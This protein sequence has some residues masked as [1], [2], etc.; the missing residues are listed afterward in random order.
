MLICHFSLT[1]NSKSCGNSTV[2][3]TL[4]LLVLPQLLVMSYKRVSSC[5]FFPDSPSTVAAT[6]QRCHR[7]LPCLFLL[8][9]MPHKGVSICHFSAAASGSRLLTSKLGQ[10]DQRHRHK[11]VTERGTMSCF[12]NVETPV[13]A[14]SSGGRSVR[15]VS[16]KLGHFTVALSRQAGVQRIPIPLDC[17]RR[18]LRK[19]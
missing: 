14:I 9:V 10:T 19:M 1:D 8:L 5:H 18:C 2:L 6:S 3:I 17:R 7:H 15:L 4:K 12:K 16:G 11:R 13:A